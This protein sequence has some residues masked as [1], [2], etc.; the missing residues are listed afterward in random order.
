MTSGRD[1]GITASSDA[2]EYLR[3]LVESQPDY[4]IF[5]LDPSGHVMSWNGGARR[6]KGYQ[7][8]EIIG[9]HFSVFYPRDQVELGVPA[10]ILESARSNG[11]HEAE[12]WRVPSLRTRQPSSSKR[13]SRPAT[14][15]SYAG[16]L[17]ARASS[18]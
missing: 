1:I 9:Q 15:S 17:R 3:L 10:R 18:V 12:G 11:R 16:C 5:L 8:D 14:S 6:L 13:P 2:A 7:A 4:A